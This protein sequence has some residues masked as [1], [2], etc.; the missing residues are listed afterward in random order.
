[1]KQLVSLF[2]AADDE[3]IESVIRRI[4]DEN[5]SDDEESDEED[6]NYELIGSK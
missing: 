5:I 1:M 2:D 3:Q 6:G 4:D